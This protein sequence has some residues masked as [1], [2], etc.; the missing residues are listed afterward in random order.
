MTTHPAG[1]LAEIAALR[2]ERNHL[3]DLATRKREERRRLT[4][5]RYVEQARIDAAGLLLI[6][7]AGGNVGREW[8][9]LPARRWAQARALLRLAGM[10]TG[11]DLRI[12]APPERHIALQRLDAA[13]ERAI[14]APAAYVAHIAP[15]LRPKRLL[16]PV[17]RT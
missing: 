2:R 15:S 17:H 14:A 9:P 5:K 11:H 3:R 4:V 12:V 10:A 8:A 13:A 16:H 7:A 6:A 1:A